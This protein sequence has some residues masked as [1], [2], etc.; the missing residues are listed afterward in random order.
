[1]LEKEI[2]GDADRNSKKGLF[3]VNEEQCYSECQE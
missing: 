2:W 3:P 1:M